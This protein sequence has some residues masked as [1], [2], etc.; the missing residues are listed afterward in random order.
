MLA[1]EVAGTR[2]TRHVRPLG[3]ELDLGCNDDCIRPRLWQQVRTSSHV[4]RS[5]S[6]VDECDTLDSKCASNE[7][8][9]SVGP[10]GVTPIGMTNSHPIPCY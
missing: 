1:R 9:D 7:W 8:P 6:E 2:P 3:R 5:A 4:V 10:H